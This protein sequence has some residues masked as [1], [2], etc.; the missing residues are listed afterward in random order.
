MIDVYYPFFQREAIWEE[1]RYSVRSVCLH[2]KEPFR[3]V[4][5][6]DKPAWLNDNP[7]CLFIYHQRSEGMKENA[8]FDA[9]TKLTIFLQLQSRSEDFIRMY[10]DTYLLNDVSIQELKVPKALYEASKLPDRTGTW[11]EQL[12][13]TLAAVNKLNVEKQIYSPIWNYETHF[14]DCFSAEKMLKVIEDY[15]A[16]KNRLLTG[17]LYF[18]TWSKELPLLFRKDWAIQFYNNEDNQFYSSST[19]NLDEK[20]QDKYF[21]NHN[22]AGLNDNLKRFLMK[23]FHKKCMFEK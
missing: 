17:T 2:L 15:G 5:I 18:N 6:G 14:P 12:R 19:G 16:L 23:R 8:T 3:L 21:L 4:I 9:I 10:D 22:N 1:L 11:W 7:N 13:K 20:C